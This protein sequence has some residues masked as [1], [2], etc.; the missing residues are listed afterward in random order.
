MA[1]HTATVLWQRGDQVFTDRQYVRAHEWRF[2]GGVTV[3]G[4]SAP[5][6]LKPPLSREDA[7]DPEEALIAAVSSCHM[8]FF[9]EFAAKG[10]F[11]IDRYEDAAEGVLEKNEAGRFWISKVT[12]QPTITWSGPKKPNREDI[13]TLHEKSHDHCFIANSLK[14]EV[15]IADIHPRFV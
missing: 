7:V 12:L 14:G 6:V 9:L 4:S 3:V 5:G 8:L 2:D 1:I 13:A 10:G 11:R 15:T